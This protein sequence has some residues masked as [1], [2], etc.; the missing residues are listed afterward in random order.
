MQTIVT[1]GKDLHPVIVFFGDD[2][3]QTSGQ[4][5]SVGADYFM[6]EDMILITVNYR[7]G[8]FGFLT[9]GDEEILPGNLALKDQVQAL[10]W[11]QSNVHVFGGDRMRVT[12]FGSGTGSIAVSMHL[13][14]PMSAGLFS[15]GISSSGTFSCPN[16]IILEPS[17]TAQKLAKLL[18]CSGNTSLELA[19]CLDEKNTTEILIAQGKLT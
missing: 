16:A 12:L 10:R 5:D 7:L 2:N 4:P 17:I 6:D 18:N 19:K 15:N 13:L 1:S 3:F 14:S 11:I 8:A 9:L